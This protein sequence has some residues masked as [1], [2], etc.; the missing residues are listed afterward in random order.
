MKDGLWRHKLQLQ[1]AKCSIMLTEHN[2]HI[3]YLYYMNCMLTKQ[4]VEILIDPGQGTP[5]CLQK[6]A[7]LAYGSR[8]RLASHPGVFSSNGLVGSLRYL[9]SSGIIDPPSYLVN[10]R[11]HMMVG[12]VNDPPTHTRTRPFQ[13]TDPLTP[14]LMYVWCLQSSYRS[15][16]LADSFL[17]LMILAAYSWP[18]STFTQR[19]TT[20]NA[21]LETQQETKRTVS[22]SNKNLFHILRCFFIQRY[23]SIFKQSNNNFHVLRRYLS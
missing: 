6:A 4:S 11:T 10:L 5:K 22:R 9:S 19:R 7:G 21:P 3:L 12:W 8:R 1:L 23:F 14:R 17:V 15:S 16:P 20:E 2:L 18:D 13:F